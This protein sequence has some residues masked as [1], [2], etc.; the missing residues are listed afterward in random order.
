M[1]V[2]YFVHAFQSVTCYLKRAGVGY[3]YY[4]SGSGLPMMAE[5]A[6]GY[7]RT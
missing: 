4:S 3:T 7:Q 5:G 6:A 1:D 2:G